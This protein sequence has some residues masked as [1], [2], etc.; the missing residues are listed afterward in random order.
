MT[1][2]TATRRVVETVGRAV[3]E[4]GGSMSVGDNW[5]PQNN[6]M[7]GVSAYCLSASLSRKSAESNTAMRLLAVALVAWSFILCLACAWMH[8]LAMSIL[9]NSSLSAPCPPDSHALLLRLT[10]CM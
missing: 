5:Y 9:C 4:V 2:A 7:D 3:D 8:M 10:R 1:E 6:R